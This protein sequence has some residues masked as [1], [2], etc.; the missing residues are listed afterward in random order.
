VTAEAIVQATD[1]PINVNLAVHA[2]QSAYRS[3]VTGYKIPKVRVGVWCRFGVGLEAHDADV[4]ADV[5][6][7]QTLSSHRCLRNTAVKA[8]VH[9][10]QW[11]P[12]HWS[13]PGLQPDR[14]AMPSSGCF[15]C[16][17]LRCAV[18][19]SVKHA[20]FWSTAVRIPPSQR[21]IMSELDTPHT[22]TTGLGQSGKAACCLAE[23]MASTF[24]HV[25]TINR[26]VWAAP[27]HGIMVPAQSP[28]HYVR[29]ETQ[30]EHDVLVVGGGDHPTG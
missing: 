7:V 26:S 13:S 2:R 21:P 30:P 4:D 9:D 15:P 3:Y 16:Q 17:E 28:Y 11:H 23:H 22:C 20:S 1:S 12:H 29:I 25:C 14:R 19:G 8:S 6:I 5:L 10:G 24:D 18:Q 27:D